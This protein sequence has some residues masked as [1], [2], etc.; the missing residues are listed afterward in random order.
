MPVILNTNL[1]YEPTQGAGVVAANRFKILA[2]LSFNDNVAN[3]RC[4]DFCVQITRQLPCEWDLFNATILIPPKQP[5]RNT[6]RLEPALTDFAAVCFHLPIRDSFLAFEKILDK[7]LSEEKK[8]TTIQSL[9][10][11]FYTPTRNHSISFPRLLS[12]L[13]INPNSK[14]VIQ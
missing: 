5:G 1:T 14:L 7:S 13:K 2:F 12:L 4:H 9:I 8:T 10:N 6:K 11:R 3:T